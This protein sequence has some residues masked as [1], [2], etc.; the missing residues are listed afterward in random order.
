[1]IGNGRKFALMSHSNKFICSNDWPILDPEDRRLNIVIDKSKKAIEPKFACIIT[2][3]ADLFDGPD[4]NAKL[5]AQILHGEAFKIFAE[6]D[7]RLQIQSE[8]DGYT[9]WIK[10]GSLSFDVSTP[11]HWVTVP[12]TFLYSQADMKSS[13]SGHRSMGSLVCVVGEAETRGTNYA[14]LSDGNYIIADHISTH[15]DFALDYVSVAEKLIHTP[16]LWGGNSAFGL[17]CSGLVQLSMRMAGLEVLRDSDMQ[18]ATIG[19]IIDVAGD[20]KNLRRGDLI[21]WPG[22]V[23]IVQGLIAG[24]MHIIHANGHTMNVKSEPAI[25][26]IERIAYLYKNPIGVRRPDSFGAR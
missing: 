3:C 16:Y 14:R 13:R 21:F 12:R 17:D 10:V 22:H 9:G 19:G 6:Q 15:D 4:S 1:M 5:D 26:A 18:A 24:E 11:T 7:E 25:E 20:D 8:R 2:S 23:A